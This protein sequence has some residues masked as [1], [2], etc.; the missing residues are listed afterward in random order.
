MKILT[1][2]EVLNKYDKLLRLQQKIADELSNLQREKEYHVQKIEREYNSQID[3][4]LREAQAISL[5]VEGVKRYVA[6]VECNNTEAIE[7]LK[8]KKR[9]Q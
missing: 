4:K 9:G 2:R 3:N 7:R 8:P 1:E 5:Q 6:D